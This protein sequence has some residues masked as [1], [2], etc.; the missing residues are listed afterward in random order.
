MSIEQ[1]EQVW[2]FVV[3]SGAPVEVEYFS[4]PCCVC[5]AIGIAVAAVVDKRREGSQQAVAQSTA[6]LRKGSSRS[7]K[8][9]FLHLLPGASGKQASQ[10]PFESFY[11][12]YSGAPAVCPPSYIFIIT[13]VLQ[14]SCFGA[15]RPP[16][17]ALDSTSIHFF[18]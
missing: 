4:P 14:A 15:W 8:N 5:S 16:L 3:K 11:P 9:E 2:N 12:V 17:F 6:R 13:I 1:P 18:F 10:A 7:G